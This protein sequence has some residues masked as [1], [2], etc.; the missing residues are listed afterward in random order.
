MNRV[1]GAADDP[2]RGVATLFGG[3]PLLPSQARA[4]RAADARS[5]VTTLGILGGWGSGKTSAEVLVAL[6]SAVQNPYRPVYGMNRPTTLMITETAKVLRDSLYAALTTVVPEGLIVREVRQ[7]TWDLHLANG[8]VLA[9]RSDAGSIEGLSVCTT[10]VDEVH[11]VGNKGDWINYSA[12]ARDPHAAKNFVV[13]AGLPVDNGWLREEFDRPGDATRECILM[14]TTDNTGLSRA[15]VADLLSRVSDKERRTYLEAE[16]QT[17][18]G[19]IYDSFSSRDHILDD[20][21]DTNAIV[22]IG[23]DAGH[24][25][26]VIVAQARPMILADGRQGTRIHVVDELYPDSTTAEAACR[27]FLGRGWRV[28]SSQ[29]GRPGTVVCVDPKVSDDQILGIQRAFSERNHRVDII[30]RGRGDPA[31]AV[32]YGIRAVQAALRDAAGNVRLTFSS[33]LSRSHERAILVG[34]PKY[35]WD[36]RT[37]LPVKD[38]LTDHALDALRYLVCQLLP[39]TERTALVDDPTRLR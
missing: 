10:I 1:A 4:V 18:D 24:R 14:R 30:K 28:A 27:E 33:K 11:K 9:L 21:G 39:P 17:H 23:L 3:R 12:R 38:N 25:G 19:A 15:Y 5:P 34:L 26:A 20:T 8:H 37:R 35:R 13:A 16:W 36:P 29:P 32:D 22:H 6:V 2:R 7:P 31:E